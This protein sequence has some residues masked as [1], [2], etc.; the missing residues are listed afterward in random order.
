[1]SENPLKTVS[2]IFAAALKSAD[3]YEA[4]IDHSEI[5][6]SACARYNCKN[7]LLVGFGKAAVRMSQ[8][9]EA[10]AGDLLTG[11]IIITKYGHGV[12][13]GGGSKVICFEA[14]HPLPDA[15]GAAATQKVLRMLED[16]DEETLV[17]CLMSGGG[18]ALLVSP[19]EGI[20]LA[21]KER[22]TELLLKAG[23]DINELNAVRKH[24][25]SIKGGRLAA[26]A[27]PAPVLSLI[28]SDV[29]GDRLDVI[30][31][32]PTA[33]DTSTYQDALAVIG[34]YGL[35]R[36][37]PAAVREHLNNGASGL[38]PETPKENDPVFRRVSNIIVGNNRAAIHAA[39][40]EAE[41]CGYE[42]TILST[43]LTGEAK[44][45]ARELVQRAVAVKRTLR[46]GAGACL[47]AGGETSVTVKGA[48]KGGRNMELALA[49][50]IGIR[51]LNGITF[52]SAGTDGTDGPTDA[53]GAVVDGQTVARGGA[54]GM[55]PQ[56][57]LDN[58]DSYTF[59]KNA[60]GL[61]ITGPTGTNVMDIQ[62]ILLDN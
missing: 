44:V 9:A 4:V 18:S 28:L 53:A 11:G 57:Y 55:D 22:T 41:R 13:T 30:A 61:V 32:G 31:S 2:K 12:R 24:L 48:G 62:V 40:E 54:A 52:L 56:E 5:I 35:T 29:I 1:M 15:N 17:V 49:F 46:P 50:G 25:S 45:V 19:P 47:L 33:P 6:S 20:T 10:A 60:G 23:A 38:I 43:A 42:T 3:P 14:G 34:K 59:F 36:S 7:I 51:E 21:D 37:V 39:M 26:V 27:Y 58:N 8:A 16:A